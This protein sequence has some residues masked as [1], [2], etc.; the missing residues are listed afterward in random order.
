MR[1]AI[2]R[3]FFRI[4]MINKTRM[5]T[6][7]DTFFPLFDFLNSFIHSFAYFTSSTSTPDAR[8]LNAFTIYH[9]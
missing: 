6:M 5:G 8:R 2:V 1:D 9:S 4:E 7:I 3:R